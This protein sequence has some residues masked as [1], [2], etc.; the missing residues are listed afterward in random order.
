MQRDVSMAQGVGGGGGQVC[1]V[2]RRRCQKK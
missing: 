1:T 2:N